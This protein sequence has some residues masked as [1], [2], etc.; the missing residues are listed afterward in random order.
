MNALSSAAPPFEAQ[1]SDPR[2]AQ[3]LQQFPPEV[4]SERLY[5][6]IELMERYSIELA[7]DLSRQLNLVDRLRKWRSTDELCRLL[8][9]QPR[10]KFALR[11]ILERLV[12]SGC[13][14]AQTNRN[15]RFYRLRYSPWEADL[16]RF[17]AV[18]LSIDPANAATLDLLDHAANLYPA[19]ASGRQSGD[20]NLL[21]P[22]GVTLWLNYFDNNN[23]TYAVN[24]WVGAM[25]AADHLST[26]DGLR[27][28]EVGA[29]TGSASEILLQLLAE[30]GLLPQIERYLITEPNAY[31][32]RCSQRKL[33]GQYPNMALE[34]APL[35]LDFPWNNQGI[36]SGEFDL[37]FAVNVMHISKNLF[38]SLNEARSILADDGWLVIGECVRPYDNQPIYPELMF[39]ILDSFTNVQTDPE[40]RPNPGFLTAEQ[41]RRAF[42]RAGFKH[43]RV[44]PDIDRI[45]EIYPHFFTG[46]ICGQNQAND[47]A[48]SRD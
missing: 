45:R 7:V 37:V 16:K 48:G 28:L 17:H 33:A 32:R 31:F 18:G 25:L 36:P 2:L 29:G 46:A 1:R 10:F 12:E 5:Q 11:W 40:V 35:D 15:I 27:I 26:G 44:A 34:W 24:N 38:F 30:R 39:Q 13:A 3:W 42:S 4:F 20:H 23:S 41:W 6:S 43:A 22:Q 9:F 8:S 47:S 19:V 14:E 21:G